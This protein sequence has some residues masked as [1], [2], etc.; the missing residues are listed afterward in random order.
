MYVYYQYQETDWIVASMVYLTK[1]QNDWYFDIE[2]RFGTKRG[3]DLLT[4]II[5]NDSKYHVYMQKNIS[6][7]TG[8]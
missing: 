2:K 3:N 1:L 7:L 6:R 4:T 5:T 8:N